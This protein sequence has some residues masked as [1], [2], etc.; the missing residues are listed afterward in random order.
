MFEC[1]YEDQFST[2]SHIVSRE[3]PCCVSERQSPPRSLWEQVPP[4]FREITQCRLADTRCNTCAASSATV[5]FFEASSSKLCQVFW[6]TLT[7]MISCAKSMSLKILCL[8]IFSTFMHQSSPSLVNSAVSPFAVIN[9]A[10]S[11]LRITLL[12]FATVDKLKKKH[13]QQGRHL[14]GKDGVIVQMSMPV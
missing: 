6:A 10:F 9:L 8:Q 4:S 1:L 13:K 2:R 11:P 5:S 7:P 14:Q 3:N 12:P